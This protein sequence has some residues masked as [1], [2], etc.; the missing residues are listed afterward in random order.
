MPLTVDGDTTAI[1]PRLHDAAGCPTGC[2]SNRLY[3][4]FDN[5]LYR[6]NGVLVGSAALCCVDIATC[7]TDDTV[8][9][10]RACDTMV[11]LY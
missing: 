3:N 8:A 6:V 2:M 9:Y 10:G 7:P 1:K 4:R 5:R 11:V